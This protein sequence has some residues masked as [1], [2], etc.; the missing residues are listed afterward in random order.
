MVY[1]AG[2]Y[3]NMGN[4]KSFGDSKIIPRNDQKSFETIIKSSAAYKQNNTKMMKLWDQVKDVIYTLDNKHKTLGL[5]E[6]GVT[7]YFSSNCNEDDAKKVKDFM[8][9]KK[10]ESVNTRVFKSVENN[11][12]VYEIRLASIETTD[13]PLV[14]LPEESYKGATFKMTRGDYSPLLK[15]VV[16]YLEQ[17]I[18]YAA[19]ENEKKML[20]KYISHFTSGSLDDH[21]DGSRYWIKDKGPIVETYIGFIETYRDPVGERAEYE[22]FVAVVDKVMSEKFATLVKNA[23]T[24]LQLLPWGKSFEKDVFLKPDFT[25][26][27]VLAFAGSGIPSGINIPNYDAIRQNEGFKNVYLANVI[28][29][30]I[31]IDS[32]PFLSEKD[33]E[34]VQKYRL[35]S[36]DVQVGLHELL[37]HGSGKLLTKSSNGSFNFDHDNLINPLTGKKI[38]KY[39]NEGETYDSKFGALGSAYEECRAEAV[40]LYLSLEKDIVKIFG[41]EG[42]EAEDVIYTNW[43]MLLWN[44]AA[45]ALEMYSPEKKQWLQAHSKAR[46][47]LLQVCLEA[48]ED[49]VK[50]VETEKGKNLQLVLNKDKINTVGK[51]AIGEFLKKLQIYKSTG[52][53]EE[54]TKLF[55]K[56]SE[57]SDSGKYPWA[58]W[59]NIVMD[60]RKPR[61][62]FVQPN[63]FL[64]GGLTFFCPH[65]FF[66]LI[67]VCC[68]TILLP[69]ID[70]M[71]FT[72]NISWILVLYVQK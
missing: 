36:F 28:S 52:D 12:V 22:G 72:V 26:L 35:P 11:T 67:L 6:K 58:T 2:M 24:F 7:T 20:Q 64:T 8:Q 38:D 1:A 56:Y 10:M 27:D 55:D 60:H 62:L 29:A 54:A 48:G 25:S 45:K 47:V 68:L 32:F 70:K 18:S 40:G 53:I 19:N 4:Y 14:T 21:K 42:A 33:I 59:R 41:Y 13:E 39:Y 15:D 3:D 61:K 49:L 34:M 57:V 63:T 31:P 44:G 30:P 23:Q 5:G 71:I 43:L 50:V 69:N 46:F 66:K 51:N 37:G 17:A 16:K 65:F 9:S